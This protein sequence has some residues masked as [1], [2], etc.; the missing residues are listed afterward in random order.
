M[1]SPYPVE[2]L[3]SW[4][5]ALGKQGAALEAVL[6]DPQ[7]RQGVRDELAAPSAFR[8][9]NGEWDKVHVVEVTQRTPS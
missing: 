8:L 6:A 4:K 1:A 7:F 5:R 2:G 9:F 3:A